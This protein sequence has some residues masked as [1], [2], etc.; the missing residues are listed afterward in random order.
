MAR[1]KDWVVYLLIALG[2]LFFG[3]FTLVKPK[4][5]EQLF[6]IALGIVAIVTGTSSLVTLNKYSF[7]KFNRTS[8]LIKGVASI[9][10]GVLAVILPI[11][12]GGVLWRIVLY[13]LAAQLLLSAIVVIIDAFAVRLLGLSP[14][15]LFLE[16][17]VSLVVSILLFISPKTIADLLVTILGVALIVVAV[18]IGV[19]AFVIRK[20]RFSQT[21]EAV[22]VE[23]EDP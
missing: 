14:A 6:I 5:F 10:I 19:I 22:E 20:K 18:A 11:T 17:V 4:L 8:T 7:A 13:V 1:K 15:P 23:I 2:L 9:I 3:V 21:I 12:M 16:G